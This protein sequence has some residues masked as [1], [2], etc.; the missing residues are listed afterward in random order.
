MEFLE[1]KE[2][3]ERYTGSRFNPDQFYEELIQQFSYPRAP[4]NFRARLRR[5]PNLWREVRKLEEQIDRVWVRFKNG[6]VLKENLFQLMIQLK[7][8][9][10]KGLEVVNHP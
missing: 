2:L 7:E 6:D 4:L 1:V 8:R 3:K 9:L 10:T 5:Y